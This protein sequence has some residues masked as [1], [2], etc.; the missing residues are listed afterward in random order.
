MLLIGNRNELAKICSGSK[1]GD[2]IEPYFACPE[3]VVACIYLKRYSGIKHMQ[4]IYKLFLI[5]FVLAMKFLNDD[6]VGSARRIKVGDANLLC[7]KGP[8]YIMSAL[9]GVSVEELSRLE[10]CL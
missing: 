4:N 1:Y 2:K 7:S 8:M 6:G 10:V 3:A 5:S 9:G